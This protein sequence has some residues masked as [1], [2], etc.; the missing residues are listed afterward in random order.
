MKGPGQLCAGDEGARAALCERGRGQG[1]HVSEMLVFLPQLFY[2]NITFLTFL[3]KVRNV[4]N[5]MLRV[6]VVVKYDYI[7]YISYISHI[8][9]LG[10]PGPIH[11][12]VWSFLGEGKRRA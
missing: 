2:H 6:A 3:R 4:R 10:G 12:K 11:H 7:S 5:V 9:T 1:S 8:S